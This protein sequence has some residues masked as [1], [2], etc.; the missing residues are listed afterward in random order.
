L[1]SEL[2]GSEIKNL[3][4]VIRGEKKGCGNRRKREREG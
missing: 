4:R 1:A 3:I 2:T